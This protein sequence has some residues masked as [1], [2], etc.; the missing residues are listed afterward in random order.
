MASTGSYSFHFL[1][2]SL[3]REDREEFFFAWA[4]TIFADFEGFGVLDGFAGLFA[5]E[6]DELVAAAV[7]YVGEASFETLPDVLTSGLSL[8]LRIGRLVGGSQSSAFDELGLDQYEGFD[9]LVDDLVDRDSDV[10]L[11]GSGFL[12]AVVGVE[13]DGVFL[14]GGTSG[15]K[16]G[17][18][19]MKAESCMRMPV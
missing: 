19:T 10:D 6:F 9:L 17:T 2:R 4:S 15:Q 8:V 11:E 14:R 13:E 16:K 18:A 5:V 12:E 3:D 7:G 1:V